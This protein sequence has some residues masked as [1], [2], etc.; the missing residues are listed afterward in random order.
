VVD[1]HEWGG[2]ELETWGTV[3]CDTEKAVGKEGRWSSRNP[4]SRKQCEPAVG[5]SA[6]VPAMPAMPA[7]LTSS[8][9][10]GMGSVAFSVL[11]R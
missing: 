9:G 6:R 8:M 7:R 5:Q 10:M 3:W 11:P 2:W 1:V 4:D